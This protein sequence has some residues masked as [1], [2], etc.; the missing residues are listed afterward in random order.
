MNRITDRRLLVHILKTVSFLFLSTVL[1][2]WAWNNAVTTLFG[3]PAIHFKE[4]LGI[5]ILAFGV[6]MLFKPGGPQSKY[7]QGN[8]S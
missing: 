3:L 1:V 6:S 2:I 7:F 4:A 8:K 5:L